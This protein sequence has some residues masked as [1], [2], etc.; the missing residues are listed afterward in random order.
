MRDLETWRKYWHLN[1]DITKY[2]RAEMNRKNKLI[3]N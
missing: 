2:K 3:L 1:K